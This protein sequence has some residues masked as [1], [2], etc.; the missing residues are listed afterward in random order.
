MAEQKES[1]LIH[2]DEAVVK[3][4]TGGF[5]QMICDEVVRYWLAV[6]ALEREVPRL[7]SY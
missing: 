3:F 6:L 1:E 4:V 5:T 2:P 7:G